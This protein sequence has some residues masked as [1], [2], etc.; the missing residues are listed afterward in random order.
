MHSIKLN[1]GCWSVE[2]RP[3]PRHLELGCIEFAIL[4]RKTIQHSVVTGDHFAGTASTHRQALTD[5]SLP[6]KPFMED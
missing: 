4:C 5:C 2:Q 3:A 6:S 1:S